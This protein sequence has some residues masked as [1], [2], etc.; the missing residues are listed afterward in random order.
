MFQQQN[1]V[2]KSNVLIQHANHFAND[3]P[4]SKKV[5]Q[6]IPTLHERKW[7]HFR[8]FVEVHIASALISFWNLLLPLS[9]FLACNI[10][11]CVD[12]GGSCV[13]EI[14]MFTCLNQPTADAS[15]LIADIL[16]VIISRFQGFLRYKNQ[17]IVEKTF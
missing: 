9:L 10:I 1:N 4:L 2:H 17:L 8:H 5:E 11:V 12:L 7:C 14:F 6:D 15:V 3:L 13:N 16:K